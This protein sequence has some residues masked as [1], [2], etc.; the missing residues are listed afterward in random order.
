MPNNS[1]ALNAF[2]IFLR[3]EGKA[4]AIVGGG[5]EA[6]AKARLIGQSSAVVRIISEAATPELLEFIA[7]HGAIHVD[8]AYATGHLEGT[9]M[10]FAA[11]GDEALDR[12]VVEDAPSP[13]HSGQCRRPAGAL[14]FLHARHWSTARPWRSRSAPKGRGRCSPR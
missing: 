13:W 1:P 3:V 5:E 14:R 9:A 6:L 4:V 2:P 10:V 11:T 12:R 7:A 8:A